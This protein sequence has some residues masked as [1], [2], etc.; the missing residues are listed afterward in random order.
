MIGP[1]NRA[2]C[3]PLELGKNAFDVRA[4]LLMTARKLVIRLRTRQWYPSVG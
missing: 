3:V 2:I 4:Q 1:D